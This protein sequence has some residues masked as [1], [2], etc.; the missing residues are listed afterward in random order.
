MSKQVRQHYQ[1]G[2]Q[3]QR[4]D[5]YSTL[6]VRAHA[7]FAQGAFAVTKGFYVRL[8]NPIV[9]TCKRPRRRRPL[10]CRST[11]VRA[12]ILGI[13]RSGTFGAARWFPTQ[14]PQEPNSCSIFG[15]YPDI[16]S[17]DRHI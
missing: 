4:D 15:P 16:T 13:A 6:R 2:S 17:L 8:A 1:K 12:I 3:G 7:H 11:S 14:F 9:R 10:R 5:P